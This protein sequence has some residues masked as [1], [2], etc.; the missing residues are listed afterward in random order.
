MGVK[1]VMTSDQKV[2]VLND[3]GTW[4]YATSS[5]SMLEK[6]R[7]LELSA[8]VIGLFKG[9]FEKLGVRIIDTGE[10]LTC[11]QRGDQIEFALGVDEDSV[12]FSLQV[13]GYQLE[14]LAEHVAKGDINEL[15]RFR[16][17][18]EFFGRNSTGKA[19]ILNNPLISNVVLRRLIGGKNL[20]H[21]Y[22]ISPDPEQEENATFTLIYVNK[23]WL[24]IPGLQGEPE[25]I[26][27]VSVAD[28]LE[29]QRHLFAGM[30]AGSWLEWLKIGRWYVGWR[31]K[32]EVPS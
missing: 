15:E 10:A 14:R 21:M 17:A 1:R 30:K 31:K 26:F 3:D 8:D 28:A 16:I 32:V 5:G 9:L 20:I 24:V 18:R 27:R 23:G 25:R 4:Q 22:L 29:L 11:I 19:N 12:D 6:W 2:I 13:Y 7:S